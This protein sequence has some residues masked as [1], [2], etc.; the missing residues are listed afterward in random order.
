MAKPPFAAVKQAALDNI[1]SLCA[2]LV[3]RGRREGEWW[4]AQVPWRA[5]DGRNLAISL[6][7]GIWRDWARPGDEGD[8]FDLMMR[9]DGC[10][11]GDARDRLASMLGISDVPDDWTPP[12]RKVVKCTDCANVWQQFDDEYVSGPDGR[13]CK[14]CLD[15]DTEAPIPTRQARRPSYPCGP[16]AKLF[17]AR[18]SH[19]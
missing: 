5:G 6:T 15:P 9:L 12:K 16:S 13:V 3:P 10:S 11:L 8:V 19:V 1:E 18:G 2:R 14:V 7:T 17:K 4:R